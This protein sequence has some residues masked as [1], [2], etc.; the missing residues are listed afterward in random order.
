MRNVILAYSSCEYDLRLVLAASLE[1]ILLPNY[2]CKRVNEYHVTK[3][4]VHGWKDRTL[5][6]NLIVRMQQ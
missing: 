6:M 1:F 4:Y 3:H 5:N 2:I